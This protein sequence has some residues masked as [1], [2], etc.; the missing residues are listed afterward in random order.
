MKRFPQSKEERRAVLQLNLVLRAG[1]RNSNKVQICFYRGLKVQKKCDLVVIPCQKAPLPLAS[2]M[3]ESVKY[4][5]PRIRVCKVITISS[6]TV[7]VGI[8]YCVRLSSAGWTVKQVFCEQKV[9]SLVIKNDRIREEFGRVAASRILYLCWSR[10]TWRTS[11]LLL[12]GQVDAYELRSLSGFTM[13]SIMNQSRW[14]RCPPRGTP[15]I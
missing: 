12:V 14:K 6:W 9:A 8:C 11:T 5:P 1:R 4:F 10:I 13:N 2:A 3:K 7:T 15:S